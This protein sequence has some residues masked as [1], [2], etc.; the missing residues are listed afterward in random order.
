VPP[1]YVEFPLILTTVVYG[2]RRWPKR[3]YA[4]HNCT[5]TLPLATLTGSPH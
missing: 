3:L 4:A 5:N 1:A 2:F